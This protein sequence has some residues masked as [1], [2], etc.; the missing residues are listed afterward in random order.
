MV[1][2]LEEISGGEAIGLASA[3]AGRLRNLEPIIAPPDLAGYT[4]PW[5]MS[6]KIC[7]IEET[8]MSPGSRNPQ[9]L[10]K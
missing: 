10:S 7:P 1:F 4:V 8:G 2:K 6:E 3:G 9:G 5:V